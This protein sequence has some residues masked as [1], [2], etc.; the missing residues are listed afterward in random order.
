MIIKGSSLEMVDGRRPYPLGDTRVV[1]EHL[2]TR[3]TTPANPFGPHTHEQ[4]ELWFLTDGE[5]L[6]RLGEREY[7]VEGGDLVIIEP[8][9][10]H[11]LRTESEATWICLG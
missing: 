6:V 10:A 9:I 3:V 8:W 4:P 5:A 1:V 2:V 7:A 11:G